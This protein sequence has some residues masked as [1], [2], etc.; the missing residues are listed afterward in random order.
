ML[1]ALKGLLPCPEGALRAV[2]GSVTMTP[3]LYN[4]QLTCKKAGLTLH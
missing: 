2:G 1:I 4:M 3:V